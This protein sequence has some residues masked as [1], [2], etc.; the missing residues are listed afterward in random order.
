M[1]S[2]RCE[3]SDLSL[4]DS[5]L[6]KDDLEKPLSKLLLLSN[7]LS[8][9]S[10]YFSEYIPSILF[11]NEICTLL[12]IIISM[13]K[14]FDLTLFDTFISKLHSNPQ[15][16]PLIE[17]IIPYNYFK[18]TKYDK[19]SFWLPLFRK[20][21]ELNITFHVVVLDHNYDF[22]YS[23]SLKYEPTYIFREKDQLIL[24]SGSKIVFDFDTNINDPKISKQK[25]VEYGIPKTDDPKILAGRNLIFYNLS[26]Y[27]IQNPDNITLNT[28]KIQTSNLYRNYY[29]FLKHQIHSLIF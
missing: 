25:P 10:I 19:I 17:S 9:N 24:S 28:L 13:I 11:N 3:D 29:I 20:F 23:K 15:N 21:H 18:N 2:L 27:L 26:I 12:K 16:I 7:L 6:L 8:D 14:N 4:N 22:T 1:A 5:E